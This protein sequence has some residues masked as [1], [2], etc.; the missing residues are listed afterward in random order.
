MKNYQTIK[1]AFDGQV[2][3]LWLARPEVHNALNNIMIREISLFFSKIETMSEVR[4]VVIRGWGK[5]FCSG[6]DL[7][8]MKNAV[9]LSEEE[10]L[11][12]SAELS[13]MFEAVFNCN[14]IVIAAVH[15]NVYG[16]GTGLVAVCDLAYCTSDA[17][18]SL[19]ETRIGMAAASI[20]PYLLQKIRIPDLKELIF[21]AKVFSGNEA[22][23]YGLLNQSFPSQEALELYLKGITSQMLENGEQ[24]LIISKRLINKITIQS[25]SGILG[26]IPGLLAQIRV[27]PEA[28]E[29]ISAFL[30]K[31]KPDWQH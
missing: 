5:S 11:K 20:T 24:A 31:R 22:V 4:I 8:W 14:K 2:V 3:T 29:G 26:Q 30:E 16:G 17:K 21:S 19:S 13:A 18:F 27:S 1:S 9:T 10:N 23:N 15:G 25:V 12:E 6:A 28:R 7:H